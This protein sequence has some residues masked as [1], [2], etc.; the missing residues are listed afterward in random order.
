MKQIMSFLLITSFVMYSQVVQSQNRLNSTRLNLNGGSFNRPLTSPYIYN[1]RTFGIMST[2]STQT[3]TEQ[4]DLINPQNLNMFEKDFA[5]DYRSNTCHVEAK[6]KLAD[7]EDS[8]YVKT[9]DGHIAVACNSKEL[10]P[11]ASTEQGSKGFIE[12]NDILDDPVA[13]CTE[14]WGDTSFFNEGSLEVT[15]PNAD[16]I[17]QIAENYHCSKIV[18]EVQKCSTI[19]FSALANNSKKRD[20][21]MNKEKV[22]YRICP[23]ASK[24][25]VG[26]DNIILSGKIEADAVEDCKKECT[27]ILIGKEDA[28]IDG[29]TFSTDKKYSGHFSAN[30]RPLKMCRSQ[31]ASQMLQSTVESCKALQAAAIYSKGRSK[32]ESN[33]DE[34]PSFDGKYKCY[35]SS[36]FNVDFKPCKAAVMAYNLAFAMENVG[37]VAEQ[38]DSLTY[39]GKLQEKIKENPDDH[40]MKSVEAAKKMMYRKKDHEVAKSIM[41]GSKGAAIAAALAAWVR[42]ATLS[43]HCKEG[44]ECCQAAAALHQDMLFENMDVKYRMVE[45]VVRAVGQSA[46]H[47]LLADA[48]KKAGDGLKK[49]EDELKEFEEVETAGF[50]TEI[51]LCKINPGHP[52]CATAPG[53]QGV[54]QATGFSGLN[55]GGGGGLLT[56]D[57]NF[58]PLEGV[59]N[60]ESGL[61][62]VDEQTKADL[63]Q[64]IAA[65]EGQRNGFVDP[66]PSAAVAKSARGGA[67][68]SGGGGPGGGSSRGL[69]AEPKK[70]DAKASMLMNNGGKVSYGNSGGVNYGGGKYSFGGNGKPAAKNPFDGFFNKDGQS[71]GVRNIASDIG[72]KNGSGIFEKISKKYEDVKKKDRLLKYEAE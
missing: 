44:K 36:F 32:R 60:F 34:F 10:N 59:D 50:D 29:N 22:E 57:N 69:G 68:G 39:Q 31:F 17:C 8:G 18:A 47:A 20:F 28:N 21:T 27:E 43:K 55:V 26:T 7:K 56:S 11:I 46:A 38:V 24:K 64:K 71:N 41:F 40:Q 66:S 67:G 61:Q 6:D 58:K 63:A 33:K 37:L 45:D 1:S 53:P 3:Q 12:K 70:D 25:Y 19:E 5:A 54:N 72:D 48:Y 16:R 35:K 62:D 52:S 15:D 2:S 49:A 13:K 65:A 9:S 51:S 23:V 42:P 14:L 30:F 4:T